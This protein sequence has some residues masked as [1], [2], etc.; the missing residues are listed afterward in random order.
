M[1]PLSAT[2]LSDLASKLQSLLASTPY[3]C[4]LLSQLTGGTTSFVFLGTLCQP[5]LDQGKRED[6]VI[7]KYAAPFASCH[8]EFLVEATR[9][10]C[11]FPRRSPQQSIYFLSNTLDFIPQTFEACML[12]ALEIFTPPPHPT[13]P[14]LTIKT[15]KSYWY[16]EAEKLQVIQHIPS[17]APLSHALRTLNTHQAYTVGH[18]LGHW[19]RSFHTHTSSATSQKLN[20]EISQNEEVVRLKY[21][22]TWEQGSSA[23]HLL[24]SYGLLTINEEQS[25]AWDAAKGRAEEEMQI[26]DSTNV[27]VVHGDFW[28]GKYVFS[29]SVS[30]GGLLFHFPLWTWLLRASEETSAHDASVLVPIDMLKDG[31]DLHVIDFEFA[32]S[33]CRSTDVGQCIG[34]LIERCTVSPALQPLAEETIRGFVGGYGEMDDEMRWRTTIY[35]GVYVVN[36][37]SRGPPGRK[38][39]SDEIRGR[40]VELVKQGLE[41]VRAGW[42]KDA[43]AFLNTPLRILFGS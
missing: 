35:V 32:H 15:P 20:E 38:D 40:A 24:S 9:A 43:A 39:Q 13:Q 34:D 11:T 22:L 21:K 18:A 29:S 3:A 12:H 26:S 17:T 7:L 30:L 16:D 19:L 41:W 27:G 10:V 33:A 23:L 25:A 1:A 6:H 5:V 2:Q 37:W 8:T 42:S 14:G 31:L 28:A 36:W 4:T